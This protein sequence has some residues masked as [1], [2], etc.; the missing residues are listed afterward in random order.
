[1]Q[2][3][4]GPLALPA[5]RDLADQLCGAMLHCQYTMN[6]TI[7]KQMCI[8]C[9]TPSPCFQTGHDR[10]LMHCLTSDGTSRSIS[11]L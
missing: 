8:R 9:P 3:H 1:M 5:V 6:L 2:V 10:V 4:M 11:L 7:L